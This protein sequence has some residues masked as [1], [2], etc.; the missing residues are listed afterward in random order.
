[1][2]IE[3]DHIKHGDD[4]EIFAGGALAED[5]LDEFSEADPLVED[6]LVPVQHEEEDDALFDFFGDDEDDRGDGMY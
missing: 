4:E 1:M 6:E 3:D 2:H 5:V